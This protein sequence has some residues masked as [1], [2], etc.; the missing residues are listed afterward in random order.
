M[1]TINEKKKTTVKITLFIATTIIFLLALPIALMYLYYI[2]YPQNGLWGLS[3]YALIY[4]AIVT[5]IFVRKHIKLATI[6][7]TILA[8]TWGA[9]FGTVYL[10]YEYKQ[11]LAVAPAEISL[12][13]Y[14]PFKENSLAVSLDKDSSFTKFKGDDIMIG[15]LPRLDG[16]TAF[17][18]VY[19]AVAQA[20][21]PKK[22]EEKYL[23]RDT[24]SVVSCNKTS[25]AYESLAN[26]TSDVIFVL[27]PSA[28]QLEYAKEKGV[29]MQFTPIGK[30]AFVFF[31][32]KDNP[33]SNISSDE[34]KGI[35]SG[36]ITSWSEVGG[37]NKSIKAYQRNEGSGSQTALINFMGDT[38]LSSP[39]TEDVVMAMAGIINQVSNY[40]NYENSIGFSFRY[41]SSEM[42]LH[43]DV[44]LLSVDGVSPT[45]ENIENGT[46]PIINNFY[47][48]TNQNPTDNTK[49]LID[50]ILSSE[51]QEIIRKTGYIP[52]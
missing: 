49:A 30:E 13:Q 37:K 33:V 36:N 7:I 31:V 19:S 46:Y 15:D 25:Y 50:W 3:L 45:A 47:A 14:I 39:P 5:F 21:Y 51:G 24:Q 42:V 2:F 6:I 23:P 11:S 8:V 44:K 34:L 4:G 29:D 17:Y 52:M 20:V 28:K 32:N 16:A 40:Y 10:L 27:D 41:Y 1:S 48:V 22:Y 35:Y 38:P 18:P 26:G 9:S 43:N 12:E